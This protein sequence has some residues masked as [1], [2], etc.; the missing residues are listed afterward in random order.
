MFDIWMNGWVG[1]LRDDW[2]DD[3]IDKDD[4]L[5]MNERINR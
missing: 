2:M 5:G 3:W 4:D 1:R